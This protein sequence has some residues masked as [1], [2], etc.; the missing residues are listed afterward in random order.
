MIDRPLY[1]NQLLSLK[2][3]HINPKFLLTMDYLPA[4]SYNGIKLLNVIDWLLE[5][6]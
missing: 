2:D 4:N 6:A 1:L 5:M 3:K